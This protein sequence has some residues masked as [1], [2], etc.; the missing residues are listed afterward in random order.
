MWKVLVRGDAA[1]YIEHP[2]FH[3]HV[4]DAPHPAKLK[5]THRCPRGRLALEATTTCA[6]SRFSRSAELR[7]G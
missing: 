5:D 2:F 7:T 1:K 6:V 3:L 4:A